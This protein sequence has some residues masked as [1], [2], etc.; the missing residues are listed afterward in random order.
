M[1]SKTENSIIVLNCFKHKHE[2]NNI[3]KFAVFLSKC[4]YSCV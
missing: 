4:S 2:F 1:D 3:E